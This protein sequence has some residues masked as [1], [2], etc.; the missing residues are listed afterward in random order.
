MTPRVIRAVYHGVAIECGEY[1]EI[2]IREQWEFF[3]TLGRVTD[4]DG[5][6]G[7]ERDGE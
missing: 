2:H 7:E 5:A 3:A 4:D 1:V 6:F